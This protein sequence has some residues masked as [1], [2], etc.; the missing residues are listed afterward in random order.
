MMVW[1]DVAMNAIE[2]ANTTDLSYRASKNK[3]LL[4]ELCLMQLASITF[5]GEKKKVVTT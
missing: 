5:S 2:K 1:S 4:V 3:R